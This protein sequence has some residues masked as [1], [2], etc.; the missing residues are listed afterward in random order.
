MMLPKY[1]E[2]TSKG[3]EWKII[4]SESVKI[5]PVIVHSF[6]MGD[7]DDPDIYAA[8]PLWE[9]QE[10]KMGKWVMEHA[11]ETPEWHRMADQFSYGYRYIIIAKLTEQDQTFWTL[12][13]KNL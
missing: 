6:T 13:W 3:T 2:G 9:W 4:N 8:N 5:T 10:S 11:I 7:V 1:Q 12:K